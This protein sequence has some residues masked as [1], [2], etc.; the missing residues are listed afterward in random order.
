MNALLPH[1]PDLLHQRA[2]AHRSRV[3]DDGDRG[4]DRALTASARRRRVLPDG[5]RRARA[6]RDERAAQKARH[7]TP[8]GLADQMARQ[9]RQLCRD[10]NISIDDFIR[11]TR[12]A[13][14]SR[15]RRSSGAA[16]LRQRR[17]LRGRSTKAGTARSTRSSFRRRSSST[18]SVRRCGRQGRAAEGGELLLPAL[19]VSADRLLRFLRDH[20]GLSPAR[21]SAQ[22]DPDASRSGPPG[23]L[24]VSRT[25]FQWGIPVPDDP[26]HVIY[27]WFD[28]L[29]NY[30]AGARIRS[31]TRAARSTQVRGRPVTHL[32]GKDIIRFQHALSGRRC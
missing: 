28:A 29:T 3:H 4:R 32:V 30:A 11:T 8:R 2:A 7:W 26:K 19:E 5:H 16:S 23:H 9:F 25:S 15:R 12:A 21:C 31:R 10:L 13:A 6:E 27:V 1:H 14:S 22:R 20:P 24:S 18:G 17:H